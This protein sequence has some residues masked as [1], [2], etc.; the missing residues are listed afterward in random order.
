MDKA[1][2]GRAS[3]QA[4]IE[5]PF[6]V[7]RFVSRTIAADVVSTEAVAPQDLAYFGGPVSGP[8]YDYHSLR[9]RAAVS[10]HLEWQMPMPFP[11]F[12]LGRFGRVP[13]TGTFAPYVN[14][15]A[16]GNRTYPSVGAGF[17]TP[18]NL[19]RI[20][21]ARGVGRG[22]RWTFNIDVSREFWRIL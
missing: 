1:T 2:T 18:F 17:L 5:R 11:G 14:A 7:Y 19:L 16:A 12:S 8:G 3:I 10:Q 21:V 4:D 13:S 20:D 9:A 6:G 15:V 22:G